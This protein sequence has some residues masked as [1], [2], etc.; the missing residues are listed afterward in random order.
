MNVKTSKSKLSKA[1]LAGAIAFGTIG[2]IGVAEL[3]NPTQAD[4]AMTQYNTN[5]V[6]IGTN[7]IEHNFQFFVDTTTSH[8]GRPANWYIKDSNKNVKLSGSSSVITEESTY[9]QWNTYLVTTNVSSL[10]AGTYEVLYTYNAGGVEY[11]SSLYFTKSSTGS[12]T[13]SY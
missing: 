2:S 3:A 9:G 12:I 1:I 7:L 11:R 6:A 5:I 8:T 10:S 4:A 13:V